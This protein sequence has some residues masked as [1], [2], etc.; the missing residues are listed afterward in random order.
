MEETL[1]HEI[2]ESVKAYVKE[3]K[4]TLDILIQFFVVE[5]QSRQTFNVP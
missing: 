5:S 3:K 1:G 2:M 4:L